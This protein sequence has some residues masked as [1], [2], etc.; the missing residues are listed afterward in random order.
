MI[1]WLDTVSFEGLHPAMVLAANRVDQIYVSYNQP[2]CWITSGND[3]THAT[4]SKHYLGRAFDFR[5]KTLPD[6]VKDA[7]FQAVRSALG[8]EFF[9]DL[10]DRGKMNEHLHVQF[11]RKVTVTT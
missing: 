5:T 10:E 1:R 4:N 11:G 6:T 2:E 7:V 8:P 3:S 9:V